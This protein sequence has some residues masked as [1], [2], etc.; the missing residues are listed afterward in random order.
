MKTTRHTLGLRGTSYLSVV[1]HWIGNQCEREAQEGGETLRKPDRLDSRDLA[2]PQVAS[3][4]IDED[5]TKERP[6]QRW[7][8]TQISLIGA[9]VLVMALVMAAGPPAWAQVRPVG[10][11]D[12]QEPGSVIVF[13]K[14]IRGT[15]FPDGFPTPKTEFEVGVV[16]PK[17]PEGGPG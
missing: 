10:L 13:P 1:A 6:M 8:S 14:F 3:P 9:A 5:K 17:T 16:C 7:K 4:T 11:S 2:A 12:S 15:V